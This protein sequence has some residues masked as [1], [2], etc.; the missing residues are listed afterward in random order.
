MNDQIVAIVF[1][2]IG[3]IGMAL[4]VLSFFFQNI[5]WL[6]MMNTL[7][8]VLCAAYG[9][10][11][12]TYPTAALNLALILINMSFPIRWYAETRKKKRLAKKAE[13]SN[14]EKPEEAKEE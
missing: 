1:E 9:F 12:K 4:V 10:M 5:R 2:V 6:R 14:E 3:Y 13:P 11:T 7:G 8:A